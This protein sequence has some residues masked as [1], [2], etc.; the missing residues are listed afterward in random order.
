MKR[1]IVFFD[2]DGTLLN[3][4]QHR[5][6]DSSILTIQKL[7]A[8]GYLVALCTGRSFHSSDALS[9][10]EAIAW[11]GYVLNNG[12]CVLDADG[13]KIVDKQLDPTLIKAV[14]DKAKRLDIDLLGQGEAWH[15]YHRNWMADRAH[16]A[17]NSPTPAETVYQGEPVYTFLVY[18][19]D[20]SMMDEFG[21][22]VPVRGNGYA[23]ILLRGINKATGA[24]ALM[25]HYQAQSCVMFGDSLNDLCMFELADQ[26]V[27]MYQHSVELERL[28]TVVV[29]AP[30]NEIMQGALAL[31]LLSKEELL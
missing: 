11:D 12:H 22:F 20:Y 16:Q 27:A 9:V 8:K 2:I 21:C 13:H 7:Q 18:G 15:L 14:I 3:P 1:T 25:E 4:R 29:S 19:Q 28:A 6:E 26:S 30:D 10:M 23:D 5:I 17:L 31:N 24:L